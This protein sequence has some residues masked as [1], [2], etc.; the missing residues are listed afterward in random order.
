MIRE[1]GKTRRHA[2]VSFFVVRSDNYLSVPDADV[3]LRLL[4]S[5][6]KKTKNRCRT[7]RLSWGIPSH[8]SELP[9]TTSLQ[10]S[11]AFRSDTFH[12]IRWLK[13]FKTASVPSLSSSRTVDVIFTEVVGAVEV[14]SSSAAAAAR[15]MRRERMSPIDGPPSVRRI[16]EEDP[17]S[18]DIGRMKVVDGPK[19]EQ[20]ALPK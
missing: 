20:I 6:S 15:R 17:P 7:S 11:L 14:P 13:S 18:S 12:G 1:G 10:R 2:A 5:L 16:S 3:W 8:S 4:L 19:A 9:S